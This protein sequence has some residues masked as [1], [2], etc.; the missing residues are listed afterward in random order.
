MKQKKINHICIIGNIG[1]GTIIGGQINKTLTL[2]EYM[3]SN[4]KNIVIY[5][6]YGKNAIQLFAGILKTV[7]SNDKIILMLSNPGYF[8]VLPYIV[9]LSFAFK[10]EIYENVI[11]GTRAKI[12]KRIKIM[13]YFE[14]RI[15][16]IYVESNLMVNEYK[17]IG[18]ENVL[19]QPTFK[20]FKVSDIKECHDPNSGILKLCTFS[21]VTKT[22]G[23]G[24]AV[25]I[26]EKL[27]NNG[28]NVEL[29]IY[30]PMDTNYEDEFMSLIKRKEKIFYYGVIEDNKVISTLRENDILLF[31]SYYGGEGFPGAFIEAMAAGLPIITAYYAQFVEIINEGH[32][33]YIIKENN[34]EEYIEK[35]KILNKDRNLLKEMKLCALNEAK[36]YHVNNVLKDM[37]KEIM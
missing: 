10:T 26:L 23:V 20:K 24:I 36:K 27:L 17:E 28:I 9:I 32:N 14:R 30:G 37:M 8:K 22:K 12:L 18:F 4:F 2:Y 19:Y 16:R 13:R 1:D 5:N 33:G 6:V 31:P 15:K 3:S 29:T 34:Q 25:E 7:A 21:R 35:I 11:G